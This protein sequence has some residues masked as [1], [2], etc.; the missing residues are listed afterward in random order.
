MPFYFQA[1]K[2]TSAE[3]S[4]IRIIAYLV[5]N[6]IA[7]IVVGSSITIFGYY[8]PF[9]WVGAAAYCVG[10]GLLYTLKV[11]S[12]AGQ[13][14]GYQLLAGIG[15]GAGFHIPFIA[16]QVVLNEKDMPTGNA[17]AIFFN[18]IGGAISISIAQNIFSNRLVSSLHL[19]A[20]G[21][22]VTTIVTAGATHIREVTTCAQL[23]GVLQAY[24]TAVTSAFTLPI[25]TS[26]IAFL[27]S[28]FVEWRS[29]KGKKVT[30]GAGA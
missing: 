28:L 22:N 12:S 1:V 29:V 9:M 26:C 20:P 3:G 25:A 18:T 11:S 13:W 5:S 15:S 2:G 19:D 14:I 17:I 23:P 24:N 10:C 16:V 6:T 30:A 21:V 7:S 8:T 4:G 27:C